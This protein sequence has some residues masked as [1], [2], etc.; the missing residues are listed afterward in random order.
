M[1]LVVLD[2]YTLNP[3]DNPWDDLRQFGELTVYDRTPAECIV[4]RAAPATVVLTNKT[5]LTADTLRQLPALR[6]VGVLATGFNVVDVA[7]ARAQGVPVANVPEYGTDSVAQHVFALLLELCHHVGDH[8]AAVRAG[9]WVTAPDFCFWEVPPL[10]LTGLVLGIVGFG[11]IGRRVAEVA[12]AF[13]MRVI[14]GGVSQDIERQAPP[15]ERTDVAGLFAAA[16]VVSLH[17]PLTADNERFVNAALLARMKSSALFLNTAR[18]G[19]VD[20]YALAA[21]LNRG[22]IAG[23]GLDVV[24][25][26]PMRPDNPLRVARNC[27]ITPHV[28]WASL[29]ARRR[30]MKATVNNIAA[31]MSGRPVNVVN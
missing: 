14:V 16:D 10:E 9:R 1:N 22:Q 27:I 25:V 29:S 30:L 6:F 2:G 11:R 3:G 5:V 26:E 31:F 4:A 7:A 24:A 20:E 12:H 28:A 13:G 18:G 21:A 19:L 23:A 17:C 15:V 8:A